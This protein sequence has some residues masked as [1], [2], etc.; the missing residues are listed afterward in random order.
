MNF[1]YT[2]REKRRAVK[3][4]ER[5]IDCMVAVQDLGFGNHLVSGALENMNT[6]LHNLRGEVD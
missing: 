2:K 6:L 1:I 3:K 5:A 4:L